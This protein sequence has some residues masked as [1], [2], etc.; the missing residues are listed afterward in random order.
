MTP[1]LALTICMLCCWSQF[2]KQVGTWTA[3]SGADELISTWPNNQRTFG[4]KHP[5]AMQ[6]RASKVLAILLNRL[7]SNELPDTWRPDNR[8]IRT[9]VQMT[10]DGAVICSPEDLLAA[11]LDQDGA[12]LYM[13]IVS[14]ITGFGLG[15]LSI[16]RIACTRFNA[17]SSAQRFDTR[18]RYQDEAG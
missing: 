4:D 11:M 2:C 12:D 6:E 14:R 10:P 13:Q 18:L 7:A 3:S 1:K 16:A 15:A 17:P 8:Q 9:Q 5:V